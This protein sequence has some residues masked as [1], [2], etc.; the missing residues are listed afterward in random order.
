[1]VQ[2][3]RRIMFTQDELV[4]AFECYRRVTPN[5]LPPGSL[6]SCV[7]AE[8]SICAIVKSTPQG[9]TID[10]TFKGMEAVKPLIRFCIENNIMMPRDGQ[11]SLYVKDGA[12][13]LYIVYN[14]NLQLSPPLEKMEDSESD[15]ERSFSP[16][17]ILAAT[18]AS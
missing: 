9:P 13:S 14:V 8:N 16:A 15:S 2:E 1:M 12:A 6:V 7:V 11:K 5:F 4:A 3:V 10:Y 18:A 17:D